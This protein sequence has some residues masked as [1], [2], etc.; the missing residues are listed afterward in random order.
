MSITAG[1]AGFEPRM[2]LEP[3]RT[4]SL[5]HALLKGLKESVEP[6]RRGLVQ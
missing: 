1:A 6:I 5:S 2:R 4:G 3:P